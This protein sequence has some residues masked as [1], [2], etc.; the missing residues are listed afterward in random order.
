MRETR[1]LKK[2]SRC[3]VIQ[4]ENTTNSCVH[5]LECRCIYF[6]SCQTILHHVAALTRTRWWFVLSKMS[7]LEAKF[8]TV[9]VRV[10]LP[11]L[12]QREHVSVLCRV[13]RWEFARMF[14]GM[15]KA[16]GGSWTSRRTKVPICGQVSQN[17][18]ARSGS[19]D[20]TCAYCSHHQS[21]C[22]YVCGHFWFSWGVGVG[23]N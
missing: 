23:G 15:A 22:M 10:T 21:V 6:F 19:A 11:D 9:M 12:S 1:A 20:R 3:V 18:S 17:P 13:T 16:Y 2:N 5:F 14:A 7:R 8:P 4:V